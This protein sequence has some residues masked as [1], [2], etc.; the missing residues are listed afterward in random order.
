[1]ATKDKLIKAREVLAA[2]SQ[3]PIHLETA[4]ITLAHIAFYSDKVELKVN[5]FRFSGVIVS[6]SFWCTLSITLS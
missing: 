5:Q 1:M 3:S 4:L 6:N 2:G